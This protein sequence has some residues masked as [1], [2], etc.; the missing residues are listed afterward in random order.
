MS[1]E[2]LV[3]LTREPQWVKAASSDLANVT[4]LTNILHCMLTDFCRLA[5]ENGPQCTLVFSIDH[6][7]TDAHGLWDIVGMISTCYVNLGW[8]HR[9]QSKNGEIGR[10]ILFSI[11]IPV[12]HA[13]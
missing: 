5:L 3:L 13:P 12:K 10:W 11:L 9:F 7:V 1:S 2:D 4:C 6:T 8:A